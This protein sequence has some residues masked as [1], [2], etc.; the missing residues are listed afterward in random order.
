M[1]TCNNSCLLHTTQHKLIFFRMMKTFPRNISAENISDDISA[2]ISESI[3]E[4]MSESISGSFSD[5]LVWCSCCD[6][7]YDSCDCIKST[8]MVCKDPWHH[9]LCEQA[10]A[11]CNDCRME[12][13]LCECLN[14]FEDFICNLCHRQYVECD[15]CPKAL[16]SC[17]CHFGTCICALAICNEN[18]DSD[19]TLSQISS[20]FESMELESVSY[21]LVD[22]DSEEFS[23]NREE[24]NHEEE[25]YSTDELN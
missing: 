19:G 6:Q 20:E 13:H 22:D 9:C 14:S 8:C 25:G 23:Y 17:G 15:E 1:S 24:Y 5:T 4:D 11:I 16:C 12:F 7:R 3:S 10:K 21:C 2:N 18:F